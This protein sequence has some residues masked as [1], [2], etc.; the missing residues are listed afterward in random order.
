MGK[1][2]NI[3]INVRVKEQFISKLRKYIPE[4]KIENDHQ[5]DATHG[6]VDGFVYHIVERG[7]YNFM[8]S[9]GISYLKN[10]PEVTW[11]RMCEIDYSNVN[12]QTW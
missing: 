4:D 1:V 8:L 12:F 2:T 10:D 9:N 3:D 5:F 6:I 7:H 11:I